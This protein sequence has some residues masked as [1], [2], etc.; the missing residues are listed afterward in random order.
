MTLWF[1]ASVVLVLGGAAAFTWL[2]R[3]VNKAI[4]AAS[5][6]FPCA[7]ILGY[8]GPNVFSALA[9]QCLFTWPACL[10]VALHA[11]MLA[12]AWAELQA[13]SARA[14]WSAR[15]VVL[16]FLAMAYAYY[17]L[18]KAVGMFI[19]WSFLVG[20]PFAFPFTALAVRTSLKKR[21]FLIVG[22]WTVLAFAAFFWSAQGLLLWKSAS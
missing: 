10:Y 4:P 12:C 7:L 11:A 15:L 3:R 6:F 8:L 9:D 5:I 21:N 2:V 13:T 18:C 17:E 16:G 14:R 20:F 19:G 22:V 1:A